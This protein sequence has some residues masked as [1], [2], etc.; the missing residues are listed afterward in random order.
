MQA[1]VNL[2]PNT[3]NSVNCC[4]SGFLVCRRKELVKVSIKMYCCNADLTWRGA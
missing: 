2:I 4:S 3:T 1:H